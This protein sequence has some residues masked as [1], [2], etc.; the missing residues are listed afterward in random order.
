[1]GLSVR[2]VVDIVGLSLA[3]V[4]LVLKAVINGVIGEGYGP[5][6]N[7]TGVISDEFETEVRGLCS[8]TYLASSVAYNCRALPVKW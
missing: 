5:V 6:L 3:S 1:M 8:S 2:N 4:F 7:D